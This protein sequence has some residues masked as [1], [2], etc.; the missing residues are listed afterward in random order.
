MTAAVNKSTSKA[1]ARRVWCCA[2]SVLLLSGCEFGGLNSLPMP[3]TAGHGA[4]AFTVTVELPDV[5][6]LAQNSPVKVDDVTVG[7]VSG[8]R[9]EQRADGTFYA[10]VR[11]S[12][13]ASV[14]LPA[15]SVVKVAQTSLLGSQHVELAA[16]TT[17][18]GVGRLSDGQTIPI[19]NAGRY[20]TTEEVLSSLGV[21]VNKGNLGALQ[22][23]TDELYTATVGRAGQFAEF[24]PRLAELTAAVDRQTGD[25]I[26]AIDKLNRFAS[27]LAGGSDKLERALAAIP[28]ALRV[29]NSNAPPVIEAFAAL[30]RF[31]TVAARVLRHTKDDFAANIKDVY[32]VVKALSDNADH[33]IS[34]LPMI[35]TFPLPQTGVRN[36]VRGD[37]LNID[38]TFDLTMRKLGET[39]FTTSPLDANMKHLSEMVNPPDWLVG[40]LANLSGQAADPFNIPP[41]PP[42]PAQG[43]S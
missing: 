36:A 37:F 22:D 8:M 16:P 5:S 30:Q 19:D 12:I 11:L 6:T 17:E 40:S 23:I 33:L 2:A 31:A 21:V 10:A 13:A 15:N 35:G 26:I 27:V 39:L 41:A 32:P 34:A 25:L 38:A 20:P 7:S 3:G 4:G 24:L 14:E 9:A 43:G 18:P 42:P 1:A 28:S 29:L